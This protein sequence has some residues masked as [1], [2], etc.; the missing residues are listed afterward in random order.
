MVPVYITVGE[1]LHYTEKLL[2]T[3]FLLTGVF[4]KAKFGIRN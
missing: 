3:N 1:A 2:G 4:S